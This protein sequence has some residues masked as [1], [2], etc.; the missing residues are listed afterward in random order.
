MKINVA[1]QLKEA[2]GSVRN[3]TFE[4]QSEDGYSVQ[5]EVRLLRTNR[6]I[7]VNGV[8]NTGVREVCSRCLDEFDYPLTIEIEEEYFITRDPVSG[9]PL[10]LPT[11]SGAF[12]L[13][14]N[15]ILDLGE[16]IRQYTLLEL[17]I[18]P[19]CREDCAGLCPQCGR[20]LNNETCN[21]PPISTDSVWAPLQNLISGEKDAVKK[22]RG[23]LKHGPS[24]KKIR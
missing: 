19:I 8:L 15:N 1:Q 6:S 7:L 14:E 22:E 18:K 10:S 23:K 21:C 24:Q 12:T 20:N 9:M 5:G 2:V 16:A 3:I 11:E 4:E 13:D 17:P